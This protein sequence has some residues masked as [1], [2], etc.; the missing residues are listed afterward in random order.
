[1]PENPVNGAV[2]AVGLPRPFRAGPQSDP[3]SGEFPVFNV[4]GPV[5]D[6]APTVGVSTDKATY[7]LGENVVLSAAVGDDFGV[8]QRRRSTTA[9]GR[10]A[11]PIASR[12][13]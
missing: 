10:S 7:H 3:I 5:N 8:K 1:M 11:A 4:P 6:S 2:P 13:R 9:R 12:T